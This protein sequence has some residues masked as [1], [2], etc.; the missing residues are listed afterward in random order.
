MAG[1]TIW[2][3]SGLKKMMDATLALGTPKVMFL[4]ASYTLDQDAHDFINDVSTYEVTGTGVAAGGVTLSSVTTT[5]TGA[6]NL[7]TLDAADIASISVDACYAVVYVDTGTPSTSPVL[8]IT[9]LSDGDAVNSIWTGVAWSA[10][11]I[12]GITAA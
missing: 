11:G 5:V 3:C 9:D 1:P 10:S 6:S 7:V 12:A 2:Y 4:S 8:T